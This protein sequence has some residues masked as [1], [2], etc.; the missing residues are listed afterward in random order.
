[1]AM[2]DIGAI[3]KHNRHPAVSKTVVR[4]IQMQN[5]AG[6]FPYCLSVAYLSRVFLHRAFAINMLPQV[7]AFAQCFGSSKV[8]IT[9]IAQPHRDSGYKRRVLKECIKYIFLK[10]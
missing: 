7:W 9:A 6:Q 2:R 1:M 8:N 5:R 4:L 3:Y 10:G